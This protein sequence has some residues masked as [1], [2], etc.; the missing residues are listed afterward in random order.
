MCFSGSKGQR[1]IN[2]LVLVFLRVILIDLNIYLGK[3]LQLEILLLCQLKI[4]YKRKDNKAITYWITTVSSHNSTAKYSEGPFT[5]CDLWRRYVSAYNGLYR[6]WWGCHSRIVWTL[7][8][9]PVQPISCDK[10]NCSRNQKKN[11]QCERAL[12]TIFSSTFGSEAF[13]KLF[14]DKL[15]SRL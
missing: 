14:G 4:T 10:R 1:E 6:S 3:F 9:S 13:Q 5:L 8:L 11:S 12:K 7:P 2:G 15:H